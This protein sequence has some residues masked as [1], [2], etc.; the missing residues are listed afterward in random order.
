MRLRSTPMYAFHP[1]CANDLILNLGGRSGNAT[2][3]NR[4]NNSKTG[5]NIIS[6]SMHTDIRLLA[7]IA[8]TATLSPILEL[9]NL[10]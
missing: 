8:S 6:L 3:K 7:F 1:Q 4:S 10:S 2:V 5:F 9:L